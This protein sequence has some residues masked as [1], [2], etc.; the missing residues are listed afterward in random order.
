MPIPTEALGNRNGWISASIIGII[1]LVLVFRIVAEGGATAP[2]AIGND[3]TRWDAFE[4]PP[5]VTAVATTGDGDAYRRLI[6]T[7]LRDSEVRRELTTFV[8]RRSGQDV[9]D[10]LRLV[11]QLITANRRGNANIF[12]QSPLQLIN[13]ERTLPEMEAIQVVGKAANAQASALA[14]RAV[15]AGGGEED[16]ERARRLHEASLTLG[17][18]LAQERLVFREF[19]VGYTLMG[20]A[21][22]GLTAIARVTGD[23]A[24]A[25]KYAAA[26]GALSKFIRDEVTPVTVVFAPDTTLETDTR[27]RT[28]AGDVAAI[29]RE[30]TADPMWRT[31]AV[32]RLGPMRFTAPNRADRRRAERVVKDL[33]DAADAAWVQQAA[34]ASLDLEAAEAARAR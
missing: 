23:E 15:R 14:G 27:A 10:D 11:D 13:H 18:T 34:R 8:D 21:L 5:E 17:L 32:L 28:H 33:A 30:E 19:Q 20:D 22:S 16:L 3:S 4:L 12:A 1:V 25:K 7:L 6:D 29:A 2:T 9:A 31:T 26:A 24:E